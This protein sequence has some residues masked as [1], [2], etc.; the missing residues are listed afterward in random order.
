MTA[1]LMVPPPKERPRERPQ[2]AIDFFES[3]EVYP[4]ASVVVDHFLHLV[5][6]SSFIL[7]SKRVHFSELHK[8]VSLLTIPSVGAACSRYRC[9]R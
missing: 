8:K 4:G 3:L 6:I 9:L 2:R 7:D 1:L 5:L